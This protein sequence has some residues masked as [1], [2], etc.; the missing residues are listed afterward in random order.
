VEENKFADLRAGADREAQQR[1]STRLQEC[2]QREALRTQQRQVHLQHA[3]KQRADKDG[4]I[5]A[6]DA[7]L[8][9]RKQ[10]VKQVSF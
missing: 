7:A 1:Q 4:R 5:R 6:Y 2:Q 8:A 3:A 10:L 9:A